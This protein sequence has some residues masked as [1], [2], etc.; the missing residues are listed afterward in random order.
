MRGYMGSKRDI[1]ERFAPKF[2]VQPSGCH[3]WT[4]CVMPNGYGQISQNGRPAYAHR[5][6]WELAFGDPGER[7][8]LHSCD[9]RKCVNVEH[10]FLGTFNENMADMVAKRRQAHGTRNGHAKL[11]EQKV[12]DIRASDDKGIALARQYGV[13]HSLVS[14]IRSGKIWKFA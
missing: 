11:D 5:V 13:S 8:V 7:Y 10:L 14:M 4:G 3:E 12:R 2:I 9:N 1:R 6:A